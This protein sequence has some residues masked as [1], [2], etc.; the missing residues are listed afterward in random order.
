MDEI[1]QT[2][3]RSRASL[4]PSRFSHEDFRKFKR[5]DAHTRKESDV[6][7][8]VIPIIEGDIGDSRCTAGQV[9]F[10]NLD[11]LTDGTLVPGNPDKYYSARP[12]QLQRSIRTELDGQIVPSTQHDLPIAPNFFL[13]IKGPDGTPAVAL[14]QACYDGALGARS[15]QS[16]RS[17][18][19]SQPTYDNNAYTLTSI[20]QGGQLKIFTSHPIPPTGSNTTGCSMTQLKAYSLTSDRG[21]CCAGIAAYRN[22][23]D[24][25]KEQRDK[26]ISRANEASPGPGL[27]TGEINDTVVS[28]ASEAST[29][30][31][32]RASPDTEVAESE[33]SFDSEKPDGDLA[34][35]M[36]ACKRQSRSPQKQGSREA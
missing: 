30:E 35:D 12:E 23:R 2:L 18:A 21:T 9:P 24:W 4:S 33:S 6:T 11:H 14:R 3:S 28:F 26:A 5:A 34:E 1:L 19:G 13:Q 17:H 27:A 7:A 31:T 15:I 20:Y 22:G 16:L 32:A 10:T 8:S 29:G 36:R 25:A